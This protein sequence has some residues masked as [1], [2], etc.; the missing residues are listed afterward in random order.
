MTDPGGRPRDGWLLAIGTLTVL[1][2]PAPTMVARRVAAAAMVVAPVAVLPLGILVAVC[3]WLAL[4]L[5]LPPAM[6]ALIMVALVAGGTRILHLDGLSDTADGFAV[7][8][9]RERALS[10]MR[11][12]PAGPAGIVA[13]V[14]MIGLQV[15]GLARLL[16]GG[17]TGGALLPAITSGA[18]VCMARGALAIGC[19]RA[20]PAARPDGL[21]AA[22]AGTVPVPLAVMEWLMIGAAAAALAVWTG[23]SWWQGALAAG[24]AA[25]VVVALVRRAVVRFGGVT[26]DVLGAAVEVALAV[27]LVVF[28]A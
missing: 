5:G 4:L 6:A 26:G 15:A 19:A 2:V 25:L 24:L 7:P 1:P 17:W 9:D 8:G 11:S 22:V 14:I 16:T 23:R 21:G 28:S 10:V 27:L 18:L 13:V 20:V 3:G 12:G